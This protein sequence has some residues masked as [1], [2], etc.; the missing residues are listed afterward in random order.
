VAKP[1][2]TIP[3]HEPRNAI[4][5][6][7]VSVRAIVG[8][9][10]LRASA[11][12]QARV[13]PRTQDRARSF[14]GRSGS[15]TR[16]LCLLFL[17]FLG[18][19]PV[20]AQLGEDHSQPDQVHLE[21]LRHCRDGILDVNA[22][23]EDRRRWIDILFS[24]DTLQSKA[25]VVEL[26]SPGDNLDAP[27]A[28]CAGIA[29]HARSHPD[30]LDESFVEPLI[31]L[32]GS[33][34]EDLRSSAARALAD[35]P[36]ADIPT[37]LG[38]IAATPDAPMAKRL[39]AIDA[40]VSKVDRR[41]VIRELM[42]LLESGDPE[43]TAR[44]V[45]ALEPVSRDTFGSNLPRWRT[46]WEEKSQLSEEN[47][48]T[49]QLHLFRD[50][51]NTLENQMRQL[52]EQADRE[53]SVVTDRMAQ[54]QREIFRNLGPEQ[55]VARLAEWLADPV[56]EIKLVS[57]ELIRA[58]MADE[59]RRPEGKVLSTLLPL[60]KEG[61]P[62][63][64]RTV[65]E[66]IQNLK[67]DT[68]VLEAVL[69][70]ITVEPE[71]SLRHALFKALGKLDSPDAIPALVLEIANPNS[72]RD[73]VREAAVALGRVAGQA[74]SNEHVQEA[75]VA[76]NSRYAL[77]P[78]EDVEL[79]GALLEAM[80][81]VKDESSGPRFLEAIESGSAALLR[82]A[83]R[84]LRMISDRSKLPR[85]R[86][87]MGDADPLVRLAA[88]E[89]V[90]ELGGEDADLE[91]VLTRL[92]P[93]IEANGLVREA[94]WTAFEQLMGSRPPK[95]QLSYA[96]RLRDMPDLETRWL[97]ELLTGFATRNGEMTEDAERAHDRIATLL[98]SQGKSTEAI[99]HLRRL[100]E[101]QTAR[102]DAEAVETG[103]RLLNAVLNAP[104]HAGVVDVINQLAC[105]EGDETITQGLIDTVAAY[106]ESPE[107]AADPEKTRS[108][109]SQLQSL[110]ADTLGDAWADLLQRVEDRLEG[111]ADDGAPPP[112][113]P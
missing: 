40:L 15:A 59:G 113:T 58:R 35:F 75:V 105:V 82:P 43:I 55:Q 98:V 68:A 107:V 79:R 99:P 51:V 81:G 7:T 61:T 70:Q 80:A 83:I 25:L 20:S 63:I 34:S 36:V 95:T 92:N 84:G 32:L 54:F 101:R 73:C 76:L 103:L 102:G 48:L 8:C 106:I 71:P 2:S 17:S 41:A 30:R 9:F 49:D 12:A 14:G 104:G 60:L 57:L 27:R 33:D 69:A 112:S 10:A 45:A 94:A 97:Q 110:K 78:A 66:I 19:H 91:S 39:A 11:R 24:Y 89:A 56:P 87:L 29:R 3:N 52:R 42:V 74:K 86:T 26:L 31:G 6:R 64:R 77:V 100:Y 96:R 53:H 21:Q 62:A 16:V 22:R 4:V 47:W 90:G 93:T 44:V 13:S 23:P 111:D 67:N 1:K 109:L 108:L 72:A 18:I 50:R 65:I 28:L 37:K 38:A 46:W 85:L 5:V 88:T